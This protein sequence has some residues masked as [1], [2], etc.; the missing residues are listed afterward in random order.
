MQLPFRVGR[1]SN[2]SLLGAANRDVRLQKQNIGQAGS[3]LLLYPSLPQPTPATKSRVR[4]SVL[5]LNA[6]TSPLPI[7]YGSSSCHK[8]RETRVSLDYL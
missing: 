4:V 1:I 8:A 5:R 3:I 7:R 2:R 6:A